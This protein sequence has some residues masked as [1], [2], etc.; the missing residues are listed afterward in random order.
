MS[1]LNFYARTNEILLTTDQ[2]KIGYGTQVLISDLNLNIK[3][4]EIIALIGEN[5]SGKSTLIR[6][7]AGV[8]ASLAGKITLNGHPIQKVDRNE[9]A[10]SIATVSTVTT[11]NIMLTGYKFVSHGR[12]PYIG[13]N[14]HLRPIDHSVI[15]ESLELVKA[16]H[17]AERTIHS[18]SDG[19]MQRLV[20]ARA[21]AQEPAL[22]FL[23]EPTVFLD[24]STKLILLNLLRDL[25]VKHGLAIV[26]ATHD[27]EYFQQISDTI[28]NIDSDQI[29]RKVHSSNTE[30]FALDIRDGFSQRMALVV[31]PT[32]LHN[33]IFIDA[34]DELK[35][36]ARQ[37]FRRHAWE[38]TEYKAKSDYWLTLGMNQESH[39]SQ[40]QWL[41]INQ[42]KL[43]EISG[44]S[45]QELAAAVNSIRFTADQMP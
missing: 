12:Y 30:D 14:G 32:L 24:Q 6:T 43:S 45:F 27:I 19:E 34:S 11:E 37:L 17:L 41:L 4:G 5:G 15:S 38:V 7:L 35:A 44:N 3:C 21:L 9:K 1:I 39:R 20:I 22:L 13:W 40:I 18:L 33:R 8:Q 16:S 36:L 25:A 42:K 31:D 2:L 10:K 26:S 29:P 23:D 28:W